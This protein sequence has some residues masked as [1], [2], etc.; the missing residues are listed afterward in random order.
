[1]SEPAAGRLRLRV[2]VAPDSFKGSLTSV[3]V[4]RA[5]ADG[6]R[7]ARPADELDLA[8]L[9]DGGDGTLAALEAAGGWERHSV[10]VHD[11]LGRPTTATWLRSS[12]GRRA[13]VEFADA[14]GLALVAPGERDPL[15]AM[16]AG[17]GE[18]LRAVL[19]AGIR[20]VLLGL[21][22]SAT[23]DGGAG[24]LAALGARLL[25]GSGRS[26]PPGGAGLE[27]LA[28]LD[29]SG[30]DGRLA[31]TRLRIANDVSNPLLGP[32]GA[33]ATYG[34]QKGAS[35]A[36]VRRLDAALAGWADRLETA[37]GC[38]A[39]ETPGAGAAGGATFGLLCLRE[40]FAALELR[41]GIELLMEAV[42][43]AARLAGA[44]LV[45][46]GEG[47][48]DAQTAFGK[49][50]AGVARQAAETGRPC[51][52]VGGGVEPEGAEALGRLGAIVV[53]AV[54]GPC[55]L[56]EAMASGAGLVE[57]AGERIARL[58]TLGWQL[59]GSRQ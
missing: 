40:R 36:Q 17:A 43:F 10:P 47:R 52:A 50:A 12:D 38:S 4:A 7:R 5:L 37:T 9:A 46:T 20:E 59:R 28:T 34:P 19:D 8:P 31:E 18:V 56:E 42:G 51:L 48:I 45:L 6:W 29:L 16:S 57:R 23:T 22:G 54:E 14:S 21:G 27:V 49:T 39:R 13:A 41:P 26:I 44:D 30:L 33:A 3:E 1:M 11:P 58:V 24:L 2:L 25:D 53:P 35:A 15:A 55:S 32:S